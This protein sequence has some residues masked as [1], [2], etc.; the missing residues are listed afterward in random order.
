MELRFDTDD[1]HFEFLTYTRQFSEESS[2]LM[3]VSKECL[4]SDENGQK[5]LTR[6]ELLPVSQALTPLAVDD[7]SS[8]LDG[9]GI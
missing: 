2:R 8:E 9:F 1:S 4:N 3:K 5:N 7:L 6:S